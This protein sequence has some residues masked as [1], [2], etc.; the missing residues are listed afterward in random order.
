MAAGELRST[1][2]D[3]SREEPGISGTVRAA[4]A[5]W[6]AASDHDVAVG[7]RPCEDGHD[8]SDKGKEGRKAILDA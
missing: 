3:K 5:A 6:R 2:K 4:G 1:G 7:V 8:D